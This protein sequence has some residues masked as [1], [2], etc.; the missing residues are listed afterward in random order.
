MTTHTHTTIITFDWN[1]MNQKLSFEVALALKLHNLYRA[2][3]GL[4]PILIGDF[5][6]EDLEH[7]DHWDDRI[8]ALTQ[9]KRKV[10][11]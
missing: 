3:K 8:G 10:T 1:E 5:I 2:R 9:Y 11:T 4:P 6:R 7:K